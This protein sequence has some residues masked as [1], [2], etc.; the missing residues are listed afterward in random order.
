MS[1][2][3]APE[4][5]TT[6]AKTAP[7]PEDPIV[8]KA[9]QAMAELFASTITALG[10]DVKKLL[11]LNAPKGPVGHV[12]DVFTNE[13]INGLTARLNATFPGM[14]PASPSPTA[15]SASSSSQSSSSASTPAPAAEPK[16]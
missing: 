4:S 2:P 7:L 14:P 16:S 8:A 11:S 13:M 10:G 15:P 6:S 5:P 1:D 3:K 12:F 9:K